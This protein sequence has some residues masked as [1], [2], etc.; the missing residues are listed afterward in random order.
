MDIFIGFLI[1]AVVI[2]FSY[3]AYL[4]S[5]G[6]WRVRSFIIALLYVRLYIWQD[7]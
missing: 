5:K 1:L 2:F 7:L 6:V 3:E 4:T